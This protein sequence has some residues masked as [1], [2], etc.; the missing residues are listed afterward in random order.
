M[1]FMPM[2]EKHK[3]TEIIRWLSVVLLA[4]S[5]GY[6]ASGTINRLSAEWGCA[7]L[8]TL[9]DVSA[10]LFGVFGIWLGMFYKP[11]ICDALKGKADAELR[12]TC[13]QIISNAERFDKVFRGMRT[14][15]VVLVFSMTVRSLKD[16]VLQFVTSDTAKY[17]LKYAVVY[18]IYWSI[19]LQAYAVIMAVVPMMDAK[20]KMQKARRDAEDTL[21]L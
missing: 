18:C 20:R 14:S 7:A 10:I 3:R 19:L 11:E 2:A 12:N 5:I 17:A 15:A 1:C 6:F 8:S 4:I 21:A 16:P 9:G 13:K